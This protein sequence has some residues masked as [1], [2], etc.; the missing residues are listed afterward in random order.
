[1]IKKTIT[2]I[3][4]APRKPN[5]KEAFLAKMA[6]IEA[7]F[8]HACNEYNANTCNTCNKCTEK[9]KSSR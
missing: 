9:C 6:L 5:S 4:P 3:M 2:F 1:M 8:A 7:R